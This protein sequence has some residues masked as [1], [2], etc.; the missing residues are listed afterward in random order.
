MSASLFGVGQSVNVNVNGTLVQQSFIGTSGQTVFNL[1]GFTYT[2]NTNSLIVY[3]NGQKQQVGRDFSE[4]S[5][6]SFTL[7]EGVIAGDYVDVIGFPELTLTSTVPAGVIFGSGYTL[8]NYVSNRI[9]SVKDY[10]FLA[11]GDGVTDDTA[12]V[13][14]A[15]TYA[16]AHLPCIVYFPTGTY[17]YTSL[18]NIVAEGLTLLGD[19][20]LQT[21]LRCT[22]TGF[23]NYAIYADAFQAGLTGND[24]TAPFIDSFNL[25]NFTIEGNS[26]ILVGLRAQGI[27]RSDWNINVKNINSATGIAYDI[28]GCMLNQMR[29]RCSTDYQIMSSIPSEGLRLSAGTRNF[30]NIGNCSNNIFI[31]P[32]FEGLPIDGRIAG[33]DQNIFLGGTFESATTYGMLI[34]TGCR[35]NTFIN[36]GFESPA[37]TADISDA[38]IFTKIQN[39]Y[40]SKSTIL[41]GRQASIEGGY[42]ERIEVQ[43]GATKNRIEDVVVKNWNLG[44]GGFFDSGTATEWKNI[45]D[46]QLA[47]FI[48]PFASRVNIT[49]TASPFTYTNTRGQY[50]EVAV[51][52]GT[53]TQ[54]RGGRAGDFWLKPFTSPTI[55]LVAPGDVLEISYSVAPTMSYIPHNGFQG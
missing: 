31:S 19:G 41:Q 21:V 2:P 1:T 23:S 12:S 7:V 32:L 45:Y 17:N 35:Y 38:G 39:C 24:A 33:G 53:V 26:S 40:S 14:A 34:S 13:L 44:S 15:I 9:L 37:S 46:Q 29:L 25:Q 27:S 28:L 4:T 3:I 52:A 30:V 16:K 47:V 51:Q 43:G 36:V 18:G 49:V 8:Q 42:F 48:Y 20:L 6:S 10:P 55:H 5:S 54:I 11:K 22:S 50:V